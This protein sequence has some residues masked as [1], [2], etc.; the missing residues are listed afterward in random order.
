[1][2]SFPV[3]PHCSTALGWSH[4]SFWWAVSGAK[5]GVGLEHLVERNSH[6]QRCCHSLCR[7]LE[8][9]HTSSS[10]LLHGAPSNCCGS[11]RRSPGSHCQRDP[12]LVRMELAGHPRHTAGACLRPFHGPRAPYDP[13]ASLSHLALELQY[14]FM[15]FRGSSSSASPIAFLAPAGFAS[16][17]QLLAPR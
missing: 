10:L 6:C 5:A 4:A 14:P 12:V 3:F 7:T 2:L 13:L 11:A 8:D 16:A 9:R 17:R 1:M 15:V